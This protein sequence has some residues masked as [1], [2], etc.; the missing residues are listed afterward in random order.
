MDG[1]QIHQSRPG[2][3]DSA[4]PLIN[5]G[6]T[7]ITRREEKVTTEAAF[8]EPPEENGVTAPPPLDQG[9]VG[10]ILAGCSN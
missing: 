1:G 6:S 10:R 8:P 9:L 5:G 2:P 3:G 7:A 4:R